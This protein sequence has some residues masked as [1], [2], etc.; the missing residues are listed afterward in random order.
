M[1]NVRNATAPK[2]QLLVRI[3]NRQG[4]NNFCHNDPERLIV[5]W[6]S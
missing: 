3:F 5:V 2:L 4:F 6:L 1:I